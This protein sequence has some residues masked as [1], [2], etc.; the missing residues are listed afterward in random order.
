[1]VDACCC[2]RTEAAQNAGPS[3]HDAESLRH[4]T[5]VECLFCPRYSVAT[6]LGGIERLISLHASNPIA[7]YWKRLILNPAAIRR[8]F[9]GI[10]VH[11][12]L[13]QDVDY[14]I[15]R[16]QY[17]CFFVATRLYPAYLTWHQPAPA[18]KEECSRRPSSP[19]ASTEKVNGQLRERAASAPNWW[20]INIKQGPAPSAFKYPWTELST[21]EWSHAFLDLYHCLWCDVPLDPILLGFLIKMTKTYIIYTPVFSMLRSL[22]VDGVTWSERLLFHSYLEDMAVLVHGLVHLGYA[23]D[24]SR[25]FAN[26]LVLGLLHSIGT[27]YDFKAARGVAHGMTQARMAN[28]SSVLHGLVTGMYPDTFTYLQRGTSHMTSFEAN[29]AYMQRV[30]DVELQTWVVATILSPDALALLS[31]LL[32]I[33][34]DELL[35]WNVHADIAMNPTPT[36]FVLDVIS[37]LLEQVP[38]VG[39]AETVVKHLGQLVPMLTTLIHIARYNRQIT[40]LATQASFSDSEDDDDDDDGCSVDARLDSRCASVTSPLKRNWSGA[41]DCIPLTSSFLLLHVLRAIKAMIAVELWDA[42]MADHD[43]VPGLLSLFEL[44]PNANLL[45]NSLLRIFLTLLDRPNGKA[46]NVL[47]RSAFRHEAQNL[48]RCIEQ[49]LI[50][51]ETP[52][53]GHV[54]RL[55]IR[56]HQICSAPTLQQELVRQYCQKSPTWADTVSR[57]VAEHYKQTDDVASAS[58]NRK[59]LDSV[60]SAANLVE[61]ASVTLHAVTQ[62]REHSSSQASFPIT[63]ADLD[64]LDDA[65]QSEDDGDVVS[66]HVFQQVALGQWKKVHLTLHKSTCSLRIASEKPASKL[67]LFSRGKKSTGFS[68]VDCHAAEWMVYVKQQNAFGLQVV[69]FDTIKEVDVT[70]TLVL[71]QRTSRDAWLRAIASSIFLATKGAD[72]NEE[73]HLRTVRAMYEASVNAFLITLPP[74]SSTFV[75]QCE[76]PEDVPFWGKYAGPAGMAKFKALV[77]AAVTVSVTSSPMLE[78]IGHAVFAEYSITFGNIGVSCVCVCRDIYTLERGLL[79]GLTRS[80]VDAEKLVAMLQRSL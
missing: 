37:A 43:L 32:D 41:L 66:G 6:L 8:V 26:S 27:A 49:G 18:K 45:H 25:A 36:V 22:Q 58:G 51:R 50:A 29:A 16:D 20:D 47:L 46:N 31:P 80:L 79:V 75:L 38:I 65:L 57:L 54:A 56:L 64:A 35:F 12:T 17:V 9:G 14:G 21:D 48:L 73:A 63:D 42:T 77:D 34:I 72:L 28:H 62:S 71:R 11:Q 15:Y 70:L 23:A 78:T 33:S 13:R 68:M 30:M 4:V 10:G 24:L 76:V 52:Y 55:G 2:D 40:F 61:K 1:M 67:R 53:H 7:D 39:L 59:R 19:E 69:G 5:S 44:H 60:G 3:S 74:G